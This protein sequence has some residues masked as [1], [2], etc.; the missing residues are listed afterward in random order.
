MKKK[1][2]IL[3][4]I[5]CV[6]ALAIAGCGGEEK[7]SNQTDAQRGG[8]QQEDIQK[9]AEELF[10]KGD[11]EK[12]RELYKA[13]GNQ[14]MVSECTYLIAKN[15]ME[16]KDYTSAMKEFE[17]IPD[18]KDA[19]DYLD[20][21]QM[22]LKY[23]KFDYDGFFKLMGESMSSMTHEEIREYMEESIAP[24]YLT[25]YDSD[26]KSMEIGKYAID[27]KTYC[28]L[29][30]DN[31]DGYI[32]FDVF[33][34]EDEKAKHHLIL[35]TDYEYAD[36]TDD[37]TMGLT[38]DDKM[39]RSF[40]NKKAEEYA[41]LR[42][43]QED[44]QLKEYY[45]PGYAYSNSLGAYAY[46]AYVSYDAE[47][48]TNV[49]RVECTIGNTGSSNIQFVASNYF[50]L[51]YNGVITN[52]RP[53]QYDYTTL[54]PGGQFTTE[55]VFNCPSATRAGDT[56]NMT[57]AMENAQI[58]LGPVPLD[59]EER[60]GFAGTYMSSSPSYDTIFTVMEN[61]DGTYNITLVADALEIHC[62]YE[63]I[64]LNE[65]NKFTIGD[66]T[67]TWDEVDNVLYSYGYDTWDEK[68]YK[69]IYYMQ[70]PMK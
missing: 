24:M 46:Y 7:P 56:F 68:D 42:E 41:A 14:E 65:K 67:Y 25:W 51:N 61:G 2:I 62:I 11:Y 39:Y 16:Q 38:V 8:V 26:D 1:K 23:E 34:S 18:Y 30:Y 60:S 50:S 31:S 33:Y 58:H 40:T 22:E 9:Q 17:T 54:A 52:A 13:A 57:L 66:E 63:N 29:S 27:G 48:E 20:K 3:A 21:C 53:T 64:T 36:V 12:A 4:V 43:Q 70:N 37:P 55:L 35:N 15:C 19:A 45:L 59:T 44:T 32:G 5:L 28:I 69:T 10:D 47:Q 49:I 6:A